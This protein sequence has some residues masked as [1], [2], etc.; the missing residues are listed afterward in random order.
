[1]R[2][3]Y[4]KPAIPALKEVSRDKSGAVATFAAEA[5]YGLGEKE[6]SREIYIRILQDTVTYDMN[7][8]NFALN[9]IDAMNDNNP[10]LIAAVQQLFKEL[11]STPEGLASYPYRTAEWLFKKW[12]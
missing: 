5:F 8:Q 9:S 4:A 2:S 1:M 7:D 11:G 6:L 12:E 3:Y 10:E